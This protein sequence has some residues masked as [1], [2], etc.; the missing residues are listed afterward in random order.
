[1]DGFPKLGETIRGLNVCVLETL[2]LNMGI[3]R[4][5][6]DVFK[7]YARNTIWKSFYCKSVQCS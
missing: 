7:T 3:E 4:T 1:M 2:L 6:A 5:V